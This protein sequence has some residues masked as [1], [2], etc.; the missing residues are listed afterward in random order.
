MATQA[1]NK[2]RAL[3]FLAGLL[4]LSGCAYRTDARAL[5]GPPDGLPANVLL[6]APLAYEHD[7]TGF[8][9]SMFRG[10]R[11]EP[12]GERRVERR[13]LTFLLEDL[14]T[15]RGYEVRAWKKEWG[16]GRLPPA[17]WE[18]AGLRGFIERRRALLEGTGAQAL[19]FNHALSR[20]TSRIRC[21]ASLQ[22][23]VVDLKEGTLLWR[24]SA[25][26]ESYFDQGDEMRAA[27][28]AAL[29]RFP[30]PA[31]RPR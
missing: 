8:Y 7:W 28:E 18:G 13:E 19:V 27:L 29:E 12:R 24:G 15:R 17:S 30:P 22:I 4:L 3:T 25:R 20:C 6:V 14:L 31:S 5:V 16:E 2:K 11:V 9:R 23:A 26:A 10:L 21:E 1:H